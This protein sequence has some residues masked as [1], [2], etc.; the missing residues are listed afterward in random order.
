MTTTLEPDRPTPRVA[1]LSAR[2]GQ[3]RVVYPPQFAALASAKVETHAHG[4]GFVYFRR[5]LAVV[6][7]AVAGVG[8]LMLGDWFASL[9]DGGRRLV[10]VG[11]L[12]VV[13]GAVSVYAWRRL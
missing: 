6:M 13:A 2:T 3:G 9:P 11:V 1:N 5:A 7:C 10:C 4:L 8:A 12:A